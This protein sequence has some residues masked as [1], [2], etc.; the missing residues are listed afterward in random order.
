MAHF[1]YR[2]RAE[3]LA[4]RDVH[5]NEDRTLR[6]WQLQHPARDIPRGAEQKMGAELDQY[7]GVAGIR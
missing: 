1:L 2:F 5:R 7:F 6:T 3:E 4:T